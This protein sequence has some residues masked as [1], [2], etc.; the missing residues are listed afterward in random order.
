LITPKMLP[1]D[2][3][4]QITREWTRFRTGY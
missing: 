3:S 2:Y 4:R 1:L